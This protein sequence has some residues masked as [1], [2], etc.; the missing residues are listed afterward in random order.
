MDKTAKYFFKRSPWADMIEGKMVT[1]NKDDGMVEFYK[2]G[3]RMGIATTCTSE[4][5][6][7]GEVSA[8]LSKMIDEGT[9]YGDWEFQFDGWLPVIV[10]IC[11]KLRGH[12]NRVT[13]QKILKAGCVPDL[14]L[15]LC[16]R[17]S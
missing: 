11:C 14:K 9:F 2:D 12:G 16:K 13:E 7:L 10:E 17:L 4:S 1:V 5:Q 8:G 6:F 15:S 3:D